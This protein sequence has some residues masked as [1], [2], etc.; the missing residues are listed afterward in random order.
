MTVLEPV[1]GFLTSYRGDTVTLAAVITG[2]DRPRKPV[3]RVLDRLVREGCLEEINDDPIA[4]RYG[5]SGRLK[6][7]PTWRIIKKPIAVNP[8]S[9]KRRTVRDRIW[10]LIRARRRFTRK[11][12]VR[13]CQA[14]LGSVEDFTQL[15]ERHGYIKV[16]GKDG[17]QKVYMLVK[18]VGPKRPVLAETGCS[19]D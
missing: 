2:A 15:L 11:E 17:R 7:N 3:L 8:K 5:E 13:L 16:I 12:L 4:N 1:V 10:S 6:R 19:D 14:S 18:D 9:P